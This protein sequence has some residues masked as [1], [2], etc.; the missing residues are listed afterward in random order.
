MRLQSSCSAGKN[1]QVPAGLALTLLKAPLTRLPAGIGPGP[2]GSGEGQGCAP[3]V[4]ASPPGLGRRW[5]AAGRGRGSAATCFPALRG[6][7]F[8]PLAS[9][10]APRYP[11]PRPPLAASRGPG[12]E[13]RVEARSR[14]TPPTPT[15]DV[16]PWS[17][18]WGSWAD[19]AAVRRSWAAGWAGPGWETRSE[20]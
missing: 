17:P 6:H 15:L 7:A 1:P 5:A 18:A 4:L 14:S 10:L 8:L 11:P 12:W 19:R 2:R 16:C 13:T 3:E 9:A 20:I